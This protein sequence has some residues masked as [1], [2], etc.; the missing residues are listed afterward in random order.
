MLADKCDELEASGAE[1][2]TAV[3][4]SCLMQIGGG[5]GRRGSPLRAMHL[6]EILASS[7]M[8]MR[9]LSEGRQARARERAAAP[10]P[11][12]SDRHDPREARPRR[13][14][15]ARLGGAPRRRPRDQGGRAGAARRVPAA[16][17]GGRD[18]RPAATSTGRRDAAEAN[19]VVVEVAR[20][21]GA[22]EVA[23]DEVADDRR[24]PPERRPRRSRDPR[25]RDRPR[26]ADPPARRRLVVAHPGARRSTATAARSATSSRARSPPASPRTTRTSSPRRRGSTCGSDSW[27]RKVGVSGANFGVAE[28]GTIC[29]VESEGNGRMCTTLP[30]V[31][32]T[33]RRHREARADVRR[34][35]GVP[36]AA[37]ALLDRR[38]DEPVHLALDRRD[39]RRRPAGAA[40]RA[41]RQRPHAR[42]R[43]TR[44]AARRC[45]ASAAAPA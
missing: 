8:S 11:A 26:R 30:E 6:A 42:A 33:D 23:E 5:L 22:T 38:A 36:A 44:S 15:A 41:A 40:R 20:A 18:R 29:V 24:D 21:H 3:D 28:T 25:A 2:C 7:S 43:A 27:T 16:V 37:A 13:R 14:R 10:Q 9:G 35:R 39:A 4:A 34:P 19:A 31:L 12:R 17:R 1:V 32:V 45:T